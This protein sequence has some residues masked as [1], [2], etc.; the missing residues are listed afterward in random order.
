MWEISWPSATVGRGGTE[1]RCRQAD[2][3]KLNPTLLHSVTPLKAKS[4]RA[5]GVSPRTQEPRPKTACKYKRGFFP[6]SATTQPRK[7][8]GLKQ[9]KSILSWFWK[10]KSEIKVLAG[11]CSL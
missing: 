5:L 6:V 4:P 10:L 9:Q 8:R 2:P 7:P 3:Q 11:P 1:I